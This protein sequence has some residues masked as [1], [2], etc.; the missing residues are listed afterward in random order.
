VQSEIGEASNIKDKCN[1]KNVV[2]VLTMITG[3]LKTIDQKNIGDTGILVFVGIDKTGKELRHIIQ[4]PNPIDEFFYKC[5]KHFETERFEELFTTK[6][7]GTV[8]FINGNET[9]IYQFNGQ[10]KKIKSINANLIK[11]QKKGGQSSVRFSRLAE[12]SRVHY[13]THVVDWLNQLIV[14]SKNNYVFGSRELKDMLLENSELKIKFETDD[15]YHVFNE[16]TIQDAYFKNLIVN[17]IFGEN[18]KV[19]NVVELL[20]RD[21]DYLLFTMDEID[22]H[23]NEVEYIINS[24]NNKEIAKKYSEKSIDLPSDHK[25]YGILQHYNVIGKLFVKKIDV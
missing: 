9:L 16:Y 14:S 10:W 8:T 19:D 15:I 17:P 20:N 6:P 25:H 12:E 1:R 5:T 22:E 24:H 23:I 11:R 13:I 21:P 4:P 2:R 3:L 7:Q 18:K